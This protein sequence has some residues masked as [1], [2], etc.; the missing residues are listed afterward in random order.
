MIL[1][2]VYYLIMG[3]IFFSIALFLGKKIYYKMKFRGNVI[4]ARDAFKARA[5]SHRSS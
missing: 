3:V 2:I 4:D 1:L 5:R